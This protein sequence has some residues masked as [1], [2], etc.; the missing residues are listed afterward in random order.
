MNLTSLYFLCYIV[1]TLFI[2]FITPKK[3]QWIVLLISSV[4][5]L[6]YDNLHISTI[7]QALIVLVPSYILGR[8]IEKHTNTKQ[9][10][11]LLI[12]GIIIKL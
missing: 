2:Y 10:K 5:F 11:K 1:I 12:L 9:G 6:F 3:F 4:I 8:K 7:L